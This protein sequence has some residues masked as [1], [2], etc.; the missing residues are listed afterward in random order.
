LQERTKKRLSSLARIAFLVAGLTVLVLLVRSAGATALASA[1]RRTLPWLPAL[2]LLDAIRVACDTVAT[3]LAYGELGRNV[4]RGPLVRAH[5]IA[6]AVTMLAPAGRT[7]AEATKAALLAR[8]VGWPRATAAATLMQ[9]L[10][11]VVGAIITVPCALAALSLTGGS[12]LTYAIA[13]QGV[14]VLVMGLGLRLASRNDRIGRIFTKRSATLDAAAGEFLRSTQ[15]GALIPLAP[16]SA[17][18]VGRSCQVAQY[19]VL[20][21]AV[22]GVVTPAHVLVAQGVNMVGLAVGVL[23][24]GQVGATDGAFALSSDALAMTEAQALA[25]AM[26][27]HVLQ[28]IG[29]IIGTLTPIV[30]RVPDDPSP[31]PPG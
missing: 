8:W 15:K 18:T 22:G 4:P 9:S 3:Y 17:L 20:A 24:P 23:V 26:L 2:L 30:W 5:V 6:N 27:V 10:T 11:L 16:L 21:I 12:V 31:S 7:A 29:I 25:V 13:A 28:V 1:M 14:G 19:G